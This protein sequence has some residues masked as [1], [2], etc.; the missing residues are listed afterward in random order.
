MFCTISR[1]ILRFGF[2]LASRRFSLPFFVV[3]EWVGIWTSLLL[4][5]LVAFNK[6][7]I[8]R[9]S[10]AHSSILVPSNH[11]LH[12]AYLFLTHQCAVHRGGLP[13]RSARLRG[14]AVDWNGLLSA[15]RHDDPTHDWTYFL[16][17]ALVILLTLFTMEILSDIKSTSR[18]PP[19]FTSRT[20]LVQGMR[21]F[22]RLGSQLLTI[23]VVGL[24]VNKLFPTLHYT[25]ISLPSSSVGFCRA[26]DHTGTR[27]F[28]PGASLAHSAPPLS[29]VARY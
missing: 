10:V 21:I 12:K 15:N 26:V 20:F 24:V 7:E 5:L 9:P 27:S 11:F 1:C 29:S 8:V 14:S 19:P 16:F 2:A 22:I 28:V 25:P 6:A 23:V 13:L 3:Y 18:S 4:L 17:A